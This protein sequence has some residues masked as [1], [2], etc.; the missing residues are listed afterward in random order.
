MKAKLPWGTTVVMIV[1]RDTDE[2]MRFAQSL[3]ESGFKVVIITV[4]SAKFREYLGRSTTS[5]LILYQIREEDE[6]SVLERKREA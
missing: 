6:M 2:L 4:Q 3:I 1:P 5:S